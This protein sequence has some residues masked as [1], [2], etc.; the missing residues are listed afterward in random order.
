SSLLICWARARIRETM[1]QPPFAAASPAR[2]QL[3][4]I[5]RKSLRSS[6]GA[7]AAI[8]CHCLMIPSQLPLVLAGFLKRSS[9]SGR[10]ASRLVRTTSQNAPPP[11]ARVTSTLGVAFALG[12]DPVR[13]DPV[14]S[15]CPDQHDATL[16]AARTNRVTA[17]A[18]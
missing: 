3:S 9:L 13:A 14:V 8:V 17:R 5:T 18:H 12:G 4:T 16:R 15:A 1:S 11:A 6:G 7:A 2:F 10:I